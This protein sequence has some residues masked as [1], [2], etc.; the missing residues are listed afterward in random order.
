MDWESFNRP[1]CYVT[2]VTARG[3][4]RSA[5]CKCGRPLAGRGKTAAA[6]AANHVHAYGAPYETV[7][8]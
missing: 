3:K 1:A 8:A 2:I 5:S 6:S 4:V 7:A